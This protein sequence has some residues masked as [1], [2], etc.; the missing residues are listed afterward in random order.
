MY[1]LLDYIHT[2]DTVISNILSP[3][4]IT[5]YIYYLLVYL[6]IPIV[7]HIIVS[8]ILGHHLAQTFFAVETPVVL[9]VHR[10]GAAARLRPVARC[11]ERAD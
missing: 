10:A 4:L 1:L 5:L 3:H 9:I 8:R 11:L 6:L 2:G 7:L